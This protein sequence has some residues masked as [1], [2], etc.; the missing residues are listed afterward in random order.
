[1]SNVGFKKLG[2]AVDPNILRHICINMTNNNHTILTATSSSILNFETHVLLLTEMKV[3][4]DDL[5][6]NLSSKPSVGTTLCLPAPGRGLD[7]ATKSFN[8]VWLTISTTMVAMANVKNLLA[9]GLNNCDML[10][11]EHVVRFSFTS[12]LLTAT[13]QTETTSES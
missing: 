9:L 3:S 12:A 5:V 8:V 7:W 11:T 1:M 13:S 10:M 6:V 4:S 2:T